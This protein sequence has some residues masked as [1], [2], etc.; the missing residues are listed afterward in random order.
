MDGRK[1]TERDDSMNCFFKEVH[2]P[3]I[4]KKAPALD[5]GLGFFIVQI[6]YFLKYIRA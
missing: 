2:A 4:L 3:L 1:K 5:I 6:S